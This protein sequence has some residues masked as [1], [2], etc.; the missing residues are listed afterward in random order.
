MDTF[1]SITTAFHVYCR[2]LSLHHVSSLPPFFEFYRHGLSF[3]YPSLFEFTTLRM[4][5]HLG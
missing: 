3:Y 4:E 5:S 1:E 2:F